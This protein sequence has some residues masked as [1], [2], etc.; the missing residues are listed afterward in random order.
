M[1]FGSVKHLELV[2]RRLEMLRTLVRLE[3]EW[4]HAFIGMKIQDSQRCAA[5]QQ[6]LCDQICIVDREITL[7][8]SGTVKQ[9]N[10]EVDPTSDAKTRAALAQ[11]AALHL[12]LQRANQIKRAILRRSKSTI[13]ALH[14]L[15]NSFA[16]TYAA[17]TALSTGTL[18]EE[19]V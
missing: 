14:N 15:F 6:I 11:M 8:Q 12:E 7:L 4:R 18:Y 10:P 3:A 1:K 9:T 19:R 5:E 13:D 2:E 16:P 17:P